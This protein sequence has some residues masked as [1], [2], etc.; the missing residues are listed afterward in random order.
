LRV[1]VIQKWTVNV[2]YGSQAAPTEFKRCIR[3]PPRFSA[4]VSVEHGLHHLAVLIAH[5]GLFV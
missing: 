5:H 1:T 2:R 3:F 4:L